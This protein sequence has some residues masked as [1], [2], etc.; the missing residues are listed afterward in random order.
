[1]KSLIKDTSFL[2]K[3]A[4]V[5]KDCLGDFTPLEKS[6]H[7]LWEAKGSNKFKG[8]F[9]STLK[10]RSN[11][12]FPAEFI[13]PSRARVITPIF[14]ILLTNYCKE[15]CQYCINNKE[16][17]C[18]RYNLQPLDLGKIFVSLYRKKRVKGLFLSSAIYKTADFSQEKILES[19][20]I[21]RKKFNYRGYLHAK[22]LP[23]ASYPLIKELFK[24]A[25]R[26]SI[27]LEFPAQKYL[28]RLSEKKLFGDLL[29]R[30]KYLSDINQRFQ[31]KSGISTQFVIGAQDETDREIL[32][33]THYL[34]RQLN[35]RR[36]Y[37]S[38]FEPQR[39]TPLEDKEAVSPLR[40]RKL[41]EADF[42]IRDYSF[43]VGDFLYDR[44]GNLILN[45]DIK[46]LAALKNKELFP[47]NVNRAWCKELMRVPGIGKKKACQ[48]LEARRNSRI[49]SF[50]KLKK[51]GVPQKA[52]EWLCY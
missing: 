44:G 16:S 4:G 36:V 13:Y 50:D 30:L 5:E 46:F 35:L 8:N 21:L 33:L 22:V 15:N 29:K 19:I 37:Y 7:H 2:Y 28:S 43:D 10:A 11:S 45:K 39:G 49:S 1:M 51:I 24:F 6:S 27:N 26:L 20:I 42:L 17:N 23:Q 48:I 25:D 47:V 34:Y 14:K 12:S 9:P 38:G 3:G 52:R 31:L 32:T 18:P 40:I 41:Y